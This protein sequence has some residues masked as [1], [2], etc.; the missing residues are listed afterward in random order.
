[1]IDVDHFK[2][3]NDRFGHAIGDRALRTLADLMR[4]NCRYADFPARY[5]GE[6]FVLALPQTDSDIGSDVALRLN[7]SVSTYHWGGVQ[8][9]LTVTISIGVA[10]SCELPEPST[11]E[12]LIDAADGRLYAAKHGGRNQVVSD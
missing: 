12:A 2:Q 3:V 8:A 9:G 6:E 10:S 4:Q 5:G 7:H 11:R 1:M